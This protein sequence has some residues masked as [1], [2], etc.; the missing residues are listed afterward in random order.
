M[1]YFEVAM[2]MTDVEDGSPYLGK[3]L[4][5]EEAFHHRGHNDKWPMLIIE[6]F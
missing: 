6:P 1:H 4:Q 2:K 3:P 5:H